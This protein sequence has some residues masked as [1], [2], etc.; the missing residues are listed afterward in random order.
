MN[1]AEDIKDEINSFKFNNFSSKERCGG[2]PI[3]HLW[4]EGDHRLYAHYYVRQSIRPIWG[5]LYG[6]KLKIVDYDYLSLVKKATTIGY[7]SEIIQ[8][9][10]APSPR[11]NF[12]IHFKLSKDIS[13]PI[14]T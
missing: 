13:T 12:S 2:Y 6:K 7:T 9:I 1:I 10:I 4:C 14:I 8:S 11:G 5:E 3:Y